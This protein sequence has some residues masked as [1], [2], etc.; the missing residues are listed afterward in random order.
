MPVRPT[1]REE[2]Y[3]ARLEFERLQKI[4]HERQQRLAAEEKKR[5]KELHYMQCPKCGMKLVEID[6]RGLK[7]DKCTECE[8]VWLD[9]G[10]LERVAQLDKTVIDKFFSVFRK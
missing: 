7:I 4:E 2:E 3:F 9:A 6:Y 10:E 5:L 1:E 8:G